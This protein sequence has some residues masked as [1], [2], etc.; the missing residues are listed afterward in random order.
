MIKCPYCSEEIQEDA[1]K[2]RF[3]GEWL[4]GKA[5]R[6]GGNLAEKG[7]MDARAISRGIKQ[8]EMDDFGRGFLGLI[9]IGI[10][11]VAGIWLHWIA[12]LV[13]FIIGLVFIAKWYYKE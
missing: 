9:V 12:G 2:C 11:V 1:K 3:C 7:S 10:S 13:I 5:E 8:K 6:T 4:T